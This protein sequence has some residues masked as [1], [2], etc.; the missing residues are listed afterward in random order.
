VVF[1]TLQPLWER[2]CRMIERE[3]L[4]DDPYFTAPENFNGNAEVKAEF[5]AV[6]LEWLLRHG[7]RDVMRRAQETG[8]MCTAVNGI[9][10]LIDDPHFA[11]RDFFTRV[12]HPFAGELTYP[13]AP[14]RMSETPWRAGRAPL[15]GEHTDEVLRELGYSTEDVGMLREEGVV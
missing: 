1:H 13:G 9:D 3:D 4:I 15:L 10:E 6:L 8:Y 5:D 7:K 14:F 12:E 11:A 2:V